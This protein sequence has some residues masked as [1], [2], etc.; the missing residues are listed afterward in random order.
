MR[1]TFA[2]F[3][4]LF[5][6]LT[7]AQVIA[8]TDLP[9]L[10]AKEKKDVKIERNEVY[11][12]NSLWGY[13]NGGADLYLEYG[14]DKMRVIDLTIEDENLKIDL[15]KME[16]AVSAYGI[17]SVNR[18]RCNEKAKGWMHSCITGYQ[19]QLATGP[20]Y[21][22][23]INQSGSEK[24]M[25]ASLALA[26]KL[27]GNWRDD[28]LQFPGMPGKPFTKMHYSNAKI[29][30]GRLGMDNGFQM[31]ATYF[32]GL[33][34]YTLMV[35]PVKEEEARFNLGF[36]TEVKGDAVDILIKNIKEKTG[37][38]TSQWYF[39]KADKALILLESKSSIKKITGYIK[40]IE[41]ASEAELQE[42]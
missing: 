41:A 17:F 31:W 29:I 22:S 18:F 13:I 21:L 23:I 25:K 6:L 16:D 24:A 32:E 33:E 15:Y 36:L 4:L 27:M 38:A 20:F 11:S 7:V 9:D 34:N 2:L 42:L 14:F 39:A 30:Q 1:Y 12:G 19:L 26:N 35:I 40:A 3:T 5:L 10:D 8:Q 37:S 28:Y